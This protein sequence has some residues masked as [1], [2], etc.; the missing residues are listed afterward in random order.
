MLLEFA[1]KNQPQRVSQHSRTPSSVRTN[2]GHFD[3]QDS[4]RPGLEGSHRD[5]PPYS[6]FY[7]SRRKLHPNGSFS[8]DSQV[9][10]PKLSQNCLGWSLGTLGAHNSRFQSPIA[11]RS[12]PKL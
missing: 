8:R 12:K 6:I 5:L 10:V 7:N 4:P 9:G 11:M 2:H 3:S 1:S